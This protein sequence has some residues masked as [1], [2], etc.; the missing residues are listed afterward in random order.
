MNSLLHYGNYYT[1]YLEGKL[2]EVQILHGFYGHLVQEHLCNWRAQH[3]ASI[4][5]EGNL[6]QSCY[7]CICDH[8]LLSEM[9]ISSQIFP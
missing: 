6:T 7:V 8:E 5:H 1:S 3:F 9:N 2:L 4:L